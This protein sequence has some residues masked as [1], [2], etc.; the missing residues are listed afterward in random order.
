ME[1][2][3]TIRPGFGRP[4]P[5]LVEL[6]FA[7]RPVV[8]APRIAARAA[9]LSGMRT[10]VTRGGDGDG[11][12]IVFPEHELLFREGATPLVIWLLAAGA[13]SSADDAW[14]GTALRQ[15]WTWPDAEGEVRRTNAAMLVNDLMAGPMDRRIRLRLFNA[16][17]GAAIETLTPTALHFLI[18]ERF[19]RPDS[20]LRDLADDPLAFES[21]V[22]VRYVTMT[23][24]P[25][26]QLMDTV[27]MAPFAIPD[28]QMHYTSLDPAWVAG[29]IHG[30]ARYLFDEGDVIE[31]GHTVP[32]LVEPERWPCAHELALLGPE[33]EVLDIDPSPHGPARG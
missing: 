23:D 22:N 6:L 28:V 3:Q 12:G 1:P 10:D 25:G 2:D 4:S 17:L 27:G 16:V 32:G 21:T 7:K 29:R 8:E 15:T 14:I 13:R 31:D 19:V 11:M 30:T 18:G 20:F 24:R 9:E 33:R 5:H 26:E